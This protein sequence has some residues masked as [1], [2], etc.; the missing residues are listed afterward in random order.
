MFNIDEKYYFE[1]TK[2]YLNADSTG[3]IF[4]K[5]QKET[6]FTK[7]MWQWVYIAKNV[8]GEVQILYSL[9]FKEQDEKPE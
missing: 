9:W 8:A 6:T 3:H 5:T 7:N 4:M 2:Q 1:L